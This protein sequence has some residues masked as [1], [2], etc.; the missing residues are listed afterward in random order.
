MGP[1]RNFDHRLADFGAGA[2]IVIHIEEHL[3]A[4]QVI[5]PGVVS[6]EH[7]DQLRHPFHD[8]GSV[9]A[10]AFDRRNHVTR[11]LFE[12]GEHEALAVAEVPLDH[13]PSDSRL[14]S[15]LIG[16]GSPVKAQFNDAFG[17]RL[18]NPVTGI[19]LPVGG[20]PL[21]ALTAVRRGSLWLHRHEYNSRA[22]LVDPRVHGRVITVT[23]ELGRERARAPARI[24]TEPRTLPSARHG[25]RGVGD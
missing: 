8:G 16:A 24:V 5:G 17:G 11:T 1:L 6:R 2:G 7:L 22:L 18:D 21:A 13:P 3:K 15:D 4:G 25:P 10:G 23:T 12:Y 19:D 9:D 14:A 20:R